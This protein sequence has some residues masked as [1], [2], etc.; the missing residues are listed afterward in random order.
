MIDV[1]TNVA[2]TMAHGCLFC[3]HVFSV[4]IHF[5]RGHARGWRLEVMT[6]CRWLR[7][8]RVGY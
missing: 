2:Y 4:A 5:G 1:R 3:L 7:W 6:P 8:S